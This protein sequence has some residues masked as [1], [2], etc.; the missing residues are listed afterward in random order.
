MCLLYFSDIVDEAKPACSVADNAPQQQL[1]ESEGNKQESMNQSY[2]YLP[3]DITTAELLDETDT[4]ERMEINEE[5]FCEIGYNIATESESYQQQSQNNHSKQ[6]PNHQ[7]PNQLHN[8]QNVNPNQPVDIHIE[9]QIREDSSTMKSVD[10]CGN[11]Q[12]NG[13]V[14]QHSRQ[15]SKASSKSLNFVSDHYESESERSEDSTTESLR[16]EKIE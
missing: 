5:L 11:D 2:M 4:F 8:N 16:D 1:E 3:A 9:E 7:N 15:G 10:D 13:Q 6:L 12:Q 14:P